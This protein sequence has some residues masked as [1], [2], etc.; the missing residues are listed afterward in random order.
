MKK[1]EYKHLR[2]T[3]YREKLDNGLTITVLPKKDYHTTFALF[4]TE[5]GAIDQ[6]FIPNGENR[7]IQFPPG[8]A[9]F[10]EHKLF[11]TESGDVFDQFAHHGASANAFTGLTK[12]AYLFSSTSYIKENI[13]T[14]LNFVLEPYFTDESVEREKEIIGQEIQM[15]EDQPEWTVAL[16]LLKNLYPNHPVSNDI[17]GT[18]NSIQQITADDL[19]RNHRTFYHPSNMQIFVAGN[20]DEKEIIEWVKKNQL[21]KHFESEK[22]IKRQFPVVQQQELISYKSIEADVVKAKV[23]IGIKG[24][25]D[26]LEGVEA[27]RYSIKMEFLLKL[28]FGET[29]TTYLKLYNER[30]IDDSFNYEHT[31]ERQ[32]DYLSIGGDAK[33]PYEL[34]M[35]LKTLLLTASES[36][37]LNEVHFDLVKKR[38]IGQEL[39]S[40][41]S[42]EY[43]AQQFV[44]LSEMEASV[45]DIVPLMEQIELEDIKQ[46]ASSFLIEKNMSVFH[47]LKRT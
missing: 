6:Q 32:I 41:N 12:T 21:D 27:L 19:Y 45:F 9:H 30:L 29:S 39:Q 13:E 26:D 28:L 23:L 22:E 42:L 16:G 18:L 10:L 25:N 47:V 46:L 15:Y 5:F 14:L 40:L 20:I 43:I 38:S 44:D 24:D 7:F 37:D 8:I 2:E 35:I 17:A 1:F 31:V 34:T 4:S 33:D 11:E 36:P 3:L